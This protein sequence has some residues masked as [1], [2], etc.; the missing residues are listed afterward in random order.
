MA[1]AQVVATILPVTLSWS[2]RFTRWLNPW[3]TAAPLLLINFRSM[4]NLLLEFSTPNRCGPSMAMEGR[5]SRLIGLKA[6]PVFVPLAFR[7][8]LDQLICL[9]EQLHD[10]PRPLFVDM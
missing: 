10:N 9:L 3:R 7:H 6:L 2:R 1:A 5:L 8:L 4:A